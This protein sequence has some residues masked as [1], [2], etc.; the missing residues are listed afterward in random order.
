MIFLGEKNKKNIYSPPHFPTGPGPVERPRT[1]G[2]WRNKPPI[3]RWKPTAPRS[4]KG[5]M[6]C[7]KCGIFGLVL[8]VQEMWGCL[9]VLDG[10]MIAPVQDYFCTKPHVVFTVYEMIQFCILHWDEMTAMI[11]H[12]RS[13]CSIINSLCWGSDQRIQVGRRMMSFRTSAAIWSLM[14]FLKIVVFL[15]LQSHFIWLIFV[16][17]IHEVRYRHEHQRKSRNYLP[18][19]DSTIC[20]TS[21]KGGANHGHGRYIPWPRM[22]A[23]TKKSERRRRSSSCAKIWIA[24]TSCRPFSS[25]S[26]GPFL[27]RVE[28]NTCQEKGW[29]LETRPS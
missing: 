17:G 5:R 28:V 1:W 6:K 29:M 23:N 2:S 13:F 26:L 20:L 3:S 22:T 27:R 18:R 4:R 14:V 25:T 15:E 16:W 9:D 21:F 19:F 10:K 8:L 11:L 12:H 24:E 7:R